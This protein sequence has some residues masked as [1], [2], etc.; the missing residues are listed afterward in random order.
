MSEPADSQTLNPDFPQGKPAEPSP[1]PAK[2]RWGRWIVIFLILAA[3]WYGG[4]Y[5]AGKKTGDANQKNK[6][7]PIIILPVARKD[8]PVTYPALGTVQ[9]YNTVTI[10]SRVDGELLSLEFT[11][12]QMVKKGDVLARIDDRTFRAQRDQAAANVARDAATLSNTQRDLA[13]YQSIG[14]SVSRQILE[15]QEATVKEAQATLASDKAALE[16]AQAQLS[17]CTI[18]APFDGRTGIRAVDVGNIVHASDTDGIVVITQLQP[19]SV[20]FSLPQQSLPEINAQLN[21]GAKLKVDA[22]DV[23]KNVIDTGV[24]ELVDNEI[25]QTTGTIKLKATFPNAELALWPGAFVN[26]R[27]TLTTHEGA[28]VIPT[29][30]IQRGPKGSYVFRYNAGANEVSVVP[31]TVGVINGEESE[32]L[33][34]INEGDQIVTDG[35]AKLQDK[36]KVKLSKSKHHSEDSGKEVTPPAVKADADAPKEAPVSD[37]P[38][39]A[40]A[41]N[42]GDVKEKPADAPEKTETPATGT[43]AKPSKSVTLDATK[44][45]DKHPADAA[46]SAPPERPVHDLSK[47]KVH[48]LSKK[49]RE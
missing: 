38:G 9:A 16:N 18:R 36:T 28:M 5:F 34:G 27:L 25:D 15:T 2:P 37:N 12:G 4:W 20:I 10:R 6:P 40:G 19:I 3:A 1:P 43:D 24:V 33:E 32:I 11:E 48:D 49:Q 41:P 26:I 42:T 22:L 29:V 46:P 21:Q 44:P 13:R 8:V 7:A 30:A 17:Y 14:D 45:E 47:P 23:Q 31:V 39:A 35:M